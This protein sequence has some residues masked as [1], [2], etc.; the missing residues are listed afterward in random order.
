MLYMLKVLQDAM[1]LFA[2]LTAIFHIIRELTEA[3][4]TPGHGS[5]KR[6]AVLEVVGAIIDAIPG[7]LPGGITRAGILSFAGQVIDIWVT[8]A[9]LTGKFKSSQETPVENPTQAA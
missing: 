9:N 1:R 8:F 4:E 3:V 6:Q 5:E 2:E 7:G